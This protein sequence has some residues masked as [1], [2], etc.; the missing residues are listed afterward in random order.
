MLNG[1]TNSE[2]VAEMLFKGL[3]CYYVHLIDLSWNFVMTN[4]SFPCLSA[5]NW[6][7]KNWELLKFHS[8]I[9][10]LTFIASLDRVAV[11][12][13]ALAEPVLS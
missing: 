12:L 8:Q 10:Y 2:H 1:A 4:D 13:D 9:V 3:S 7:F 5:V 6:Q 11:L